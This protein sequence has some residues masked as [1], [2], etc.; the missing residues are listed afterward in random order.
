[1]CNKNHVTSVVCKKEA[2]YE[3]P[4]S[5]RK[6]YV[7]QAGRCLNDRL[8][9]HRVAMDTTPSG[10]LAISCASSGCIP[11]FH[12]TEAV[13]SYRGKLRKK[14]IQCV[15]FP[16]FVLNDNGVAFLEAR[17]F[18][19]SATVDV[20]PRWLLNSWCCPLGSRDHLNKSLS[21]SQCLCM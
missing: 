18:K 20:L 13:G 3:T 21:V 15:S 5:C 11:Q 10:R 9:G 7:G 14:K 16:S 6:V 1:M 12:C 8:H 2:I 17:S 19:L 4:F